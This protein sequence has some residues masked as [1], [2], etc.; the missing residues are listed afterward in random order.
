[1]TPFGTFIAKRIED[2]DYNNFKNSVDDRKL[3]DAYAKVWGDL[4][5]LNEKPD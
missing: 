5:G 4:Y 1:V 3:H 2:I